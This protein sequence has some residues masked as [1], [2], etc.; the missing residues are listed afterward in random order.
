MP[1]KVKG[2]EAADVDVDNHSRWGISMVTSI[3]LDLN[4]A[5]YVFPLF[6]HQSSDIRHFESMLQMPSVHVLSVFWLGK[7][8][9]LT[10]WLSC[11]SSAQLR[12]I[13]VQLSVYGLEKN[14]RYDDVRGKHF[15]GQSKI[16]CIIYP[17]MCILRNIDL[18]IYL[19]N[20]SFLFLLT[21][22]PKKKKKVYKLVYHPSWKMWPISNTSS[23]TS[24]AGKEASVSPST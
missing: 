18:P 10:D 19:S 15:V 23:Q 14:V 11:C 22:P 7:I 3:T 17:Q 16:L 4:S 20:H 8:L 12:F 21:H 13:R 5:D 1:A 2:T 24:R 6:S 9:L